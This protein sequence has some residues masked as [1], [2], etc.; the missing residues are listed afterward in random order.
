LSVVRAPR[1]PSHA[2]Y[3][4]G[5]IFV[6]PLGAGIAAGGDDPVEA[7][8]VPGGIVLRRRR[9][10][11]TAPLTRGGGTRASG[12]SHRSPISAD[13]RRHEQPN[14]HPSTER[15]SLQYGLHAIGRV[16]FLQTIFHYSKITTADFNM[17][18]PL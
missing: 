15:G 9:A 7:V 5:A 1:E 12:V 14:P 16:P 6:P 8:A 17:R 4:R 3:R 2:R 10:I 18:G 13:L 11:V